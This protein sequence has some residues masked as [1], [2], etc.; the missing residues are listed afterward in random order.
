MGKIVEINFKPNNWQC[1]KLGLQWFYG[2]SL[3]SESMDCVYGLSVWIECT[4]W[5]YGSS[6]SIESADWIYGFSQWGRGGGSEDTRKIILRGL[7]R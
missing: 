1:Q 5:V 4:D 7:K 6:P 3:R 2:L